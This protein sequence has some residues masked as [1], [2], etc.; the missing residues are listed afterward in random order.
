MHV[1]DDVLSVKFIGDVRNMVSPRAVALVIWSLKVAPRGP[2]FASVPAL[3][4][5]SAVVVEMNGHHGRARPLDGI[6]ERE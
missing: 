2:V 1:S 6:V 5:V 4:V 3:V